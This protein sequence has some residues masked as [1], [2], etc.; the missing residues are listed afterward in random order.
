MIFVTCTEFHTNWKTQTKLNGGVAG[1][2][3]EE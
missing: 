3:E 1:V 2:G